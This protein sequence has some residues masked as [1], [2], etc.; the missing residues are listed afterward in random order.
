MCEVKSMILLKDRVYCPADT[1]SHSDMLEALK[2]RDDKQIAN[3]VKVEIKP[4]D[5]DMFSPLENWRYCV[6]QDNMP[7]WY[8]EEVDKKRSYEALAEWANEHILIGKNNFELSGNGYFYLKD[9]KDVV[10]VG[11]STS[12]HYGNS[13]SFHYDNSTSIIP[14]Y[15]SSKREQF[16]L[17]QNATLKDCTTKTIYQA[18]D[19]NFVKVEEN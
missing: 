2:I 9:C 1:D 15:S 5:G 17:S 8:V 7:D 3:F 18:G 14:L 6:D 11:N 19:W 10:V 12:K 4:F 16:I 13:T